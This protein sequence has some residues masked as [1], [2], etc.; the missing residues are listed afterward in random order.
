MITS[1]FRLT[2][3]KIITD[4]KDLT[5]N[6]RRILLS[7]FEREEKPIFYNDEDLVTGKKAAEM[8]KVTPSTICN[9]ARSGEITSIRRSARKI[10]YLRSEIER[11][12]C[13]LP[14]RRPI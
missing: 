3:K 14:A 11:K 10:F 4:D 13:G 1:N 5:D 8:L 12:M 2:M 9:I 6:E 7:M